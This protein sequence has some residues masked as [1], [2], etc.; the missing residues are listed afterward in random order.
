MA[1]SKLLRRL[2]LSA[3]ERLNPPKVL[4]RLKTIQEWASS[5]IDCVK[6][7]N[8]FLDAIKEAS[9]WADAAFSAAKDSV[10]PIK[11]VV[12]L[13]D[14]LTKIQDPEELARLA[15]TL[16]YQSAAEKAV[17]KAGAPAH[18]GVSVIKFEDT[19]DEVDFSNFT[20]SQA[21][22]HAFVAQSD[23][24]LERFLPSGGFSPV[25]ID[26]IIGDIHENLSRELDN[27]LTNGKSK[28]KFDPLFRW[29]QL[30]RT[31]DSRAPPFVATPTMYRGSSPR[32]P[33]FSAS[34]THW[35]MFA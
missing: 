1:T 22:T 23:R 28:E 8:N 31:A 11:F 25:Q 10:A 7:N 20:L 12:K 19:I 2:N 3:D 9:P 24:I 32:R 30:P 15:C 34:P 16:A 14:E 17:E 5:A 33:C 26:Q 35:L 21:V 18:T 27:L 13:F 4:G 6:D 29:L